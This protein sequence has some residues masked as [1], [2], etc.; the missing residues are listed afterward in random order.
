MWGAHQGVWGAH[1]G[2][3][4]L[5]PD[6]REVP[7]HQDPIGKRRRQCF[8]PWNTSPAARGQMEVA[9]RPSGGFHRLGSACSEQALSRRKP[10]LGLREVGVLLPSGMEA[11]FL[12][13]RTQPAPVPLES[14]PTPS[15]RCWVDGV[16]GPRPLPP[17]APHTVCALGGAATPRGR[18][19]PVP[20]ICELIPQGA[21]AAAGAADPECGRGCSPRRYKTARRRRICMK[22][23][24][25]PTQIFLGVEPLKL[26]C[27]MQPLVR[28]ATPPSGRMLGPQPEAA[29]VPCWFAPHPTPN[30]RAGRV[31]EAQ[32][33]F[34]HLGNGHPGPPVWAPRG[35]REPP[36]EE[37][38]D[39][40]VGS[41]G[42]QLEGAEA[43]AP[44]SLNGTKT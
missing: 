38:S 1:R 11:V 25:G 40:P 42:G 10:A 18:P 27:K 43:W 35:P 31:P 33:R 41:Q 8:L 6:R 39:I 19:S 44:R 3:R 2:L 13:S 9:G 15:R 12:Q 28:P 26:V 37:R 30:P 7:R 36:G 23:G 14:R 21:W 29:S 4:D 24:R 34:T 32:T 22:L 17:P 16:A 5:E 20:P